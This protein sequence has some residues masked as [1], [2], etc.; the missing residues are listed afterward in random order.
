MKFE[1]KLKEL[2]KIIESLQKPDIELEKAV[3]LYKKG[4]ELNEECKEE[5]DRLKLMIS[6]TD[7]EEIHI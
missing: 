1:L 4:L 6:T 5:L 2:D 7:G 3:E